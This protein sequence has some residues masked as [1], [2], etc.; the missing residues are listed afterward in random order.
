MRP[1]AILILLAIAALL[2]LLVGSGCDDL[3]TEINNNTFFDSTLGEDCLRCHSD[4]DNAIKQPKGQWANSRHA[5]GDLIEAHVVLNTKDRQTNICGPQCH[6][7]EGFIAYTENGSTA[8]QPAPSAIDCFTCHMPHTGVYGSWQLD[9]LRGL[10]SPA[11]LTGNFDY[12]MGSSNMCV[13][14]HQAA[15]IPTITAGTLTIDLDTLGAD[16]PHSG[17]Q[18]H[19]LIGQGGFRF[20]AG[21]VNNSHA[22]V[23]TQ[24]GCMKCHFGVG[25]GYSYGEHTFRL[26]D[27]LSG[28]QYLGNCNISGCHLGSP[29]TDFDGRPIQDT[30]RMLSDSLAKLMVAANILTGDDEDSTEY[31]IDSTVSGDA[32]RILFNYLFVKQDGSRGAHNAKYARTLLQ[33]SVQR[34]DSLPN[35]F[36]TADTLSGCAP[37]TVNFTDASTGAILSYLWKFGTTADDS[38]LTENASFNYVSAGTYTATLTVRTNGGQD[39]Y[40]R[41]VVVDSL[42]TAAFTA[43]D[44]SVFTGVP[45]QFTQ[46]SL[47]ATTWLWDFGNGT[48]NAVDLNPSYA[49]PDTGSFVVRLIV[50]NACASDTAETTIVV[51]TP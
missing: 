38:A 25:V 24:D 42:P 28:E 7:S 20:T 5:S 6:T 40:S 35:A 27:D 1:V 41:T 50:S 16:G 22:S 15:K 47:H 45:L 21:A 13:T 2:S 46:T 14:C 48:T 39:S 37:L 23:A 3:T 31:Y 8:Q 17:T 4:D 30:I 11:I 9:T 43:A 32:A 33:E 34:W 36:F 10:E 51:T 26:E 44:D 12:D 49:F 29:L 18:A 19:M